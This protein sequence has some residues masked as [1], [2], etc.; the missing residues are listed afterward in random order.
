MAYGNGIFMA[1]AY[2]QLWASSDGGVT[3]VNRWD[4][5]PST[6][7]SGIS[8][9]RV[10]FHGDCFFLYGNNSDVRVSEDGLLWDRS[11]T[12]SHW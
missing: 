3:W 8:L 10:H 11:Y 1:Y 12:R 5:L 7:G 6:E 2:F 4:N 9:R